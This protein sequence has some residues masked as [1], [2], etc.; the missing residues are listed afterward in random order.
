MSSKKRS[1]LLRWILLPLGLLSAVYLAV[2]FSELPRP[3]PGA[4]SIRVPALVEASGL[5]A[6]HRVPNLLWSQND[7]G[8]QPVLYGYSAEGEPRGTL[9]IKGVKNLD[10]EAISSFEMDGKA[11]IAIGDVG[12]NLGHHNT[13]VVHI[14]EEPG[15][16]E[17]SPSRETIVPVAWSVVYHYE[18]GPHDCEAMIVDPRLREILL[19]TKR[20]HPA[21]IYALPLRPTQ[22]TGPSTA[23]KIGTVAHVPRPNFK[24]RLFPVPTGRFHGQITDAA[25]SPDGLSAAVLTYGDV[26][27]YRRAPGENWSQAFLHEPERLSPHGLQQAEAICFSPD[28]LALFVTGEQKH[29]TLLRYIVPR[30]GGS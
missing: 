9:R 10:W 16:A 5:A 1:V 22:L 17:L 19:I 15:A 23:K 20:T 26:L 14:I 30:A 21:E 6:S 18:T 3:A 25:L 12:D 11:W 28:G 24:Q 13:S 27:I 4:L 7:S 8:G 29:P 2:L